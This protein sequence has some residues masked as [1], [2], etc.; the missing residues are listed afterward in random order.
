MKEK[1]IEKTMLAKLRELYE[2]EFGAVLAFLLDSTL[3]FTGSNGKKLSDISIAFN[4]GFGTKMD[5]ETLKYAHFA[6][7][8]GENDDR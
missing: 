3:Y 7:M 6:S 1:D 2:D 4:G 8:V 5:C